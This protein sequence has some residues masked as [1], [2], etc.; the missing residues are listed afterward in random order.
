VTI[1]TPAQLHPRIRELETKLSILQAK[2]IAM[3]AEAAII[4]ARMQDAPS[5]GN[6][7]DNRVRLILGEAPIPTTAPDA[8]RLDE[9][10]RDLQ[11]VNSAI[12]V[13]VHDIYN[14]KQ[15]GS[16]LVCD[17]VRPEVVK[18]AKVFAKA[19][20]A[21]HAAHADY[22]GFIDSIEGNGTNVASLNRI[23]I[24]SLGSTRD[25]CAGYHYSLMDFV[26]GKIISREEL[27][28]AVR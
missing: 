27:P 20:I 16:R 14:Q 4:R 28:V 2:Q 1:P 25:P 13:L 8:E 12:G 5:N 15:M 3:K 21:L 26:D 10:L 24:N 23:F 7:Y 18:R 22:D 6:A 17:A 19:F 11:A 9:L